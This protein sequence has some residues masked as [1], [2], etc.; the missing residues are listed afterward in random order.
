MKTASEY[1]EEREKSKEFW[2]EQNSIEAMI[3]D[4]LR[5]AAFENACPKCHIIRSFREIENCICEN[6]GREGGR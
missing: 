6:C 2:E 4:K 3:D 1:L 5:K